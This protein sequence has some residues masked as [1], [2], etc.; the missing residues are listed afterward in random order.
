MLASGLVAG[1]LLLTA[2]GGGGQSAVPVDEKAQAAQ[3][4]A[5]SNPACQPR[6]GSFYWEIGDGTGRLASGQVGNSAPGAGEALQIASASKW[7]YAAYVA[8]R[9]DGKLSAEDDVPFLNFTSG[10]TGL[11]LRLC[12]TDTVGGC[13]E[14]DAV[15][16]TPANVGLFNYD[17]THMQVHAAT[18]FADLGGMD[19]AALSAEVSR[20]LG[21]PVTYSGVTLAASG[22][23]SSSDYGKFLQRI[24]SGELRIASLLG[25][26]SVCASARGCPGE[27]AAI[28]SPQADL[29]WHYGL[30]HWI[31]D[32]PATQAA[33]NRAY[34]SA[35]AFGF[36]PWI[37]ADLKHYGIIARMVIDGSEPSGMLSAACG[38]AMR[39]AYASG[40]PQL[41]R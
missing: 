35:G 34:S 37:D 3:A 38:A 23:M 12:T 39:R 27:P 7:L 18:R 4:T 9:L 13:V 32:D 21:S 15:E 36:Y 24:V 30:G 20:V 2:C 5:E 19:Q 1:G 16:R 14:G 41:I 29:V 17:S 6:I 11:E 10:Y 28:N 8:E 25:L 33:G 31:E 26:H 40:T 22:R